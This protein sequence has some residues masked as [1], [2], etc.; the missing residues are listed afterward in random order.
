MGSP[1]AY[2]KSERLNVDRRTAVSAS[3]MACT[4]IRPS[5]DYSTSP[6][7][8]Y[9]RTPVL[10]C[11][12]SRSGSSPSRTSRGYL[13]RNVQGAL[14]RHLACKARSSTCYRTPRAPSAGR[15]P[16]GTS[17]LANEILGCL[18]RCHPDI[19]GAGRHREGQGSQGQGRKEPI[20]TGTRLDKGVI[21]SQAANLLTASSSHS[22]PI[23]A[24]LGICN[25]PA[26]T[27]K[28]SFR[29][30]SAQSCHSSQCAV[31][32]TRMRCAETSG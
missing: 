5:T 22:M 26:A 12:C 15:W 32:V 19:A 28:G 18:P 3:A 1:Y 6:K 25:F 29:T 31:S 11:W 8:P 10:R 16:A 14:P 2:V 30:G 7:L 21:D 23:P 24:L 17:P 27:G 13:A 20:A 4:R 9:V